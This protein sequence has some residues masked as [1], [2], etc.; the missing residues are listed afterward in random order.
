MKI[1]KII[2]TTVNKITYFNFPGRIM[3]QSNFAKITLPWAPLTLFLAVNLPRYARE[4]FQTKIISGTLGNFFF[5]KIA[6]SPWTLPVK[7]K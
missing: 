7:L 4:V 1:K 3:R 6:L 5:G 2:I